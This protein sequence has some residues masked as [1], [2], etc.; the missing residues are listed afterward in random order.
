[1]VEIQ[2]G[3][4]AAIKQKLRALVRD[5]AVLLVYPIAREKWL[6]KLPKEEG[7]A[8]K[9]R[10]SPKRG[11]V[12]EVFAELVRLPRLL[13][14]PGF[15]LDVVL[16]QEEELRRYEGP[17]A[18]RRHGWVIEERRLLEV[19]ERH[20]FAEPTDLV[21]LLPSDLPSP[22]TTA[23]LAEGLGQSRRLAQQMAY[24]LRKLELITQVGKRGRSILY[25]RVNA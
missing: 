12:E 15:S 24:C 5:H 21:I 20:R 18:W 3:N 14:E 11:V 2:T 8:I 7:G 6:L 23:D 19:V 10:K 13:A 4:F 9:R 17:H 1:L 16:T 22:F 25:R